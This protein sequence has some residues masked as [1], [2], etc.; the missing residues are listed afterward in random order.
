[1]ENTTKDNNEYVNRNIEY[2][3]V[4]KLMDSNITYQSLPTPIDTIISR[5]E[6]GRYLIPKYQRNY[7][8]EEKQVVALIVSLLKDI[9]IP[10]LYMYSNPKDGK[11]TI[12]DGQQRITSLFFF[13]K[14]IFPTSKNRR[15]YYDFKDISELVDKYHNAE[16]K[17]TEENVKKDLNKYGLRFKDFKL[18]T[19][20]KE[21][22]IFTYSNFTEK[23]KLE[24]NNKSLDFGVVSVKNKNDDDFDND[25]DDAFYSVYTDIFRLLNSA[26]SPL[27]NQEIRNG[28][29]FGSKLYEKINGFHE[30]NNAWI[31]IKKEDDNRHRNVEFLLKLLALDKYIKISSREEL[32]DYV[33][34]NFNVNKFSLEEVKEILILEKFST[35]SALVDKYSKEYSSDERSNEVDSEVAKLKYFVEGIS[36]FPETEDYIKYLNL[37]AF[38]V[39]ASKLGILN[40]NFKITYKELS[41][42]LNS[43][44]NS[45]K[46][47]IFKRILQ[48][49]NIIKESGEYNDV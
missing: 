45:T 25:N 36:N 28:I 6:S 14:G 46:R 3:N 38:F 16:T 13:V 11:Y 17:K 27:T 30:N 31:E 19:R 20:D 26:G 23:E 40:E 24:F 34:N 35:Y 1:M 9:P 5:M 39:A 32:L 12:I 29:Y 10:R 21:S 47:E 8:W 2:V 42:E 7:V 49:I 22:R 18:D 43:T 41:K 15:H 48:A 33:E 44:N 4:E 37:E